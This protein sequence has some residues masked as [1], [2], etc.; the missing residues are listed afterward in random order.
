MQRVLIDS[1]NLHYALELDVQ[2]V[3]DLGVEVIDVPFGRQAEAELDFEPLA[4]L[5]LSLS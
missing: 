3:R 2:N 1:R 4:Q 5:I